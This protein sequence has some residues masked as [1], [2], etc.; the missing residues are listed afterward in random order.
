M[1]SF[2]DTIRRVAPAGTPVTFGIGNAKFAATGKGERA[3]PTTARGVDG[4]P[5][6]GLKACH[7]AACA[8]AGCPKRHTLAADAGGQCGGCGAAS[9]ALKNEDGEVVRGAG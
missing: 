2:A 6:R 5:L 7:S 3:V 9:M 4:R 8:G 1:R